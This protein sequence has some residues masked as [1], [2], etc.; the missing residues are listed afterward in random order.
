[1]IA[2]GGPGDVSLGADDRVLALGE[3]K[4][5]L[6]VTITADDA[7]LAA[8][9]E[10]ATGLA[11]QFVGRVLIARS[12]RAVIDGRTTWRPLPAAP[13]RSITGVSAIDEVGVARA[14]DPV[15]YAIDIDADAAGWVRVAA[16][17]RI[18]V[19]LVA[20]LADGWS[21]VP[22]PLRQGIVL[23]AAHLFSQR[24]ARDPPPAAVTA[25]WRPYRAVRLAAETHA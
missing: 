2:H 24:E 23:L 20:G 12:M 21:G 25:L 10:T 11:E 7:L 1:M 22:T 3:V 13:V 17:G 19:D 5:V 8:F 4:P 16:P 6:A 9:V 14:L 18:A 15:A